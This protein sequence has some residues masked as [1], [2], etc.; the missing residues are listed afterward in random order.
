MKQKTL[1]INDFNLQNFRYAW[2]MQKLIE[3][4]FQFN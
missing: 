1:A 2:L 3:T 4:Y